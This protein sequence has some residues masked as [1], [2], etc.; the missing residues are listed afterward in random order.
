ME[1][2]LWI[3]FR[4]PAHHVTVSK[5]NGERNIFHRDRF[6]SGVIKSG[7]RYHQTQTKN[8][9]YGLISLSINKFIHKFISCH[10]VIDFGS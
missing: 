4:S 1:A 5:A 6:W 3:F 9:L 8:R 7:H 10:Q 2:F